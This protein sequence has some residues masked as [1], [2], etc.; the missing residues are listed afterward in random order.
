MSDSASVPTSTEAQASLV[1]DVS[2]FPLSVDLPLSVGP[3]RPLVA[4]WDPASPSDPLASPSDPLASPS[5]ITNYAYVWYKTDPAQLSQFSKDELDKIHIIIMNYSYP[6][7]LAGLDL[8]RLLPDNQKIK[9]LNSE[10]IFIREKMTEVNLGHIVIIQIPR[11]LYDLFNIYYTSTDHYFTYTCSSSLKT[12]DQFNT[13]T[14]SNTENCK[15]SIFTLNNHIINYLN[16]NNYLGSDIESHYHDI[17]DFLTLPR[18]PRTL[19]LRRVHD[20]IN[21]SILTSNNNITYNNFLQRLRLL[22]VT[23]DFEKQKSEGRFTL[24][25]AATLRLD[26]V[27]TQ[28]LSLNTSMLTGCVSDHNGACTFTLC[29]QGGE[30]P[31]DTGDFY[32]LEKKIKYNIKKFLV[33]DLSPEDSL[34]FIP[35]IHPFL[36][37][38]CGGELFHAR[39]K[40]GQPFSQSLR[41]IGIACGI[42]DYLKSTKTTEEL[43]RIYEGYKDRDEIFVWYLSNERRPVIGPA[44]PPPIPQPP[45]LTFAQRFRALFTPAASQPQRPLTP[46]EKEVWKARLRFHRG[47]GKKKYFSKQY[48]LRRKKSRRKNKSRRNK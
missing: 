41:T 36:Q 40:F 30:T 28:T 18:E 3:R 12:L 25:R 31:L 33:G 10:L 6:C 22:G 17:L 19:G 16:A 23:L 26:N 34:F 5:D 37:I 39:T 4:P 42:T 48:S 24:Y 43:Q 38:Y 27:G 11:I 1:V 14:R 35:P 45:A 29:L 15:Q 8:V 7:Y 2:D 32:Y 21:Y 20:V 44:L 13:L 47:G 46:H 9:L